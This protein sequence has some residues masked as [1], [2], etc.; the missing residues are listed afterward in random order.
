ML[1]DKIEMI[2]SNVVM[3][4]RP[5]QWVKNLFVF[6]PVF[7]DGM[8]LGNRGG[9]FLSTLLIFI[10][11]CLASSSVYCFND[12]RD[13]EYDRM[14]REKSK[15]PVA[16]G[17]LSVRSAYAV[18]A[19]CL[20]ATFAMVTLVRDGWTAAIVSTYLI[21]NFLYCV[22]LKQVAI[23]DVFIIAS[24]Y[25]FRVLAGGTVTGTGLS[26]WIMLMTFLLSLFL[27]LAK[28]R[29]DVMLYKDTGIK[30]RRCIA[31][32][33]IA[34][35]DQSLS[36]LVSIIMVCY[37]MYTVS[38]EVTARFR[39]PLLY[40]TSIFVLSGLFRYLLLATRCKSGSPP[41][42][43]FCDRFILICVLLWG[44]TYFYLIYCR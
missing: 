34:F 37:I 27:A 22:S 29:D 23:V 26:H 16:S 31:E 32:Y 12:I 30:A 14:H 44:I 5:H 3:L 38:E 19:F 4:L 41:R 43:L 35:I 8:L 33:N 39:S 17:A 15:R 9:F 42:I 1:Y 25:V 7:F 13:R 40:L 24:G 18:M 21:V 36:A 20:T 10:T 28:R 2:I 6:L 11:F